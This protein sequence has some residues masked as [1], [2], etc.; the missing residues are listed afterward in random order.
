M[1]ITINDVNKLTDLE[2]DI[3]NLINL[4]SGLNAALLNAIDPL[5]LPDAGADVNPIIAK[6]A[7]VQP[8]TLIQ[9]L[10]ESFDP[11]VAFGTAPVSSIAVAALSPIAPITSQ[12]PSV[13]LPSAA[14]SN[15]PAFA[16]PPVAILSNPVHGD[17]DKNGFP[18][19]P[20]IHS[21]S[22]EKNQDGSW[23]YKR[24]AD[25]SVIQTVEAQLRGA[26]AAPTPDPLPTVNSDVLTWPVMIQEL[27]GMLS[28]QR[29][30]NDQITK[31]C[32]ES[33]VPQF[34]MLAARPDLF[35]NVLFRCQQLASLAS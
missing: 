35:K 29:I 9:S 32:A 17:T 24:G 11:N 14:V 1:Q 6:H 26:L 8:S 10:P 31:I 18:W 23:R 20:D 25:K 7:H 21:S 4:K 34:S 28:T 15:I 12:L 16:N 2:R 3:L 22:K 13:S 5:D 19:H 27:T 30:T 33:G